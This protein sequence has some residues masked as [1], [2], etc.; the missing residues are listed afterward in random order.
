MR[1]L[2]WNHCVRCSVE[3]PEDAWTKERE[4]LY[5]ARCVCGSGNLLWEYRDGRCVADPG[6]EPMGEAPTPDPEEAPPV[7]ASEAEARLVD[8]LPQPAPR[9]K[10]KRGEVNPMQRA[11][12]GTGKGKP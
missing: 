5:F 2:E 7:S 12:F 10:L 11:L 8:G 6:E 9:K 4:G 3:I 1:L